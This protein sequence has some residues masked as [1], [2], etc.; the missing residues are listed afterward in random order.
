MS[1]WV[2]KE[3]LKPQEWSQLCKISL[4][5]HF[6]AKNVN[7]LISHIS[8][9]FF[10]EFLCIIKVW[11]AQ[12]IF[13]ISLWFVWKPYQIYPQT[14]MSKNNFAYPKLG[15]LWDTLLYH[16]FGTWCKKSFKKR[17]MGLIISIAQEGS[18][19]SVTFYTI[20]ALIIPLNA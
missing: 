10:G 17:E 13:N 2:S 15:K 3:A 19:L 18:T 14:S 1:I 11:G 16:L 7:I 9:V 8:Y 20:N 4:K 6:R 12:W 5:D